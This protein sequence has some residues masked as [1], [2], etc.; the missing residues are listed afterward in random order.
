MLR[1]R[2]VTA[3][4]LLAVLLPALFAPTAWP[5]AIVTAVLIGGAGWEWARLNA[6]PGRLAP[7]AMGIAV[8]LAA[9]AAVGAGWVQRAP[10][11]LWWLATLVWLVGGAL[12]LRAG[13]AAWPQVPRGLRWALGLALLWLSWLAL[14]RSRQAGL[15]F[16]LSVFCLVWTAD[17]AAYAGGRLFGRRKLAPTVSP[18]KTWE[19]V[20][21]AIAC[22]LVLGFAWSAVEAGANPDSPS[23]YAALQRTFGLAGAAVALALLVGFSVVGDLLES[24]VKR[25]AGAKD[26]SRLLPGHGGVLDRVDALLPVFPA[27]LALAALG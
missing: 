18:G 27:A 5:F 26:S 2:I 1:T 8:A 6:V 23:L 24:L 20:W 7:L 14:A 22:V 21:S 3:A 25:A 9:L 13:V 19:G 4:I 12:A 15:N 17:I 16:I 11:P 10:A